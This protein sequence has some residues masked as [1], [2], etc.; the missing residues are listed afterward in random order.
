MYLRWNKSMVDSGVMRTHGYLLELRER[1]RMNYRILK[2]HE[3]EGI[4]WGFIVAIVLTGFGL[5]PAFAFVVG[6]IFGGVTVFVMD[7]RRQET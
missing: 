7:T 4:L 2:T 1:L 3:M 5:A 6:I